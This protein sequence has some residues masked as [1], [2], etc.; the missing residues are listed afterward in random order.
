MIN[1]SIFDTKPHDRTFLKDALAQLVKEKTVSP[2]MELHFIKDHANEETISFAKDSDVVCFFVND[3]INAPLI[4]KL[5]KY[6]VKLIA[7]R[8]AGFNNV[9]LEYLGDKIPIVRV[10]EYSPHAVAEHALALLMTINRK[11]HR[12]YNR[13]R[14]INFSLDGFLGMDLYGKTCGVIGTGKIGATFIKLMLGLG[15]KVI[16]YDVYE[17]EE[18]KK[19][20]NF[21]YVDLDS[22]FPLSDVISLHCPLLP[23]TRYIINS[24]T[25][26]RMKTGVILINTS[27]GSLIHTRDLVQALINGKVGAAGLD[28]YEEEAAYFFEDR[29]STENVVKDEVLARLLGMSNVLMTSH[30]SFFTKEALF[31][32]SKTTINN[33]HLFFDTGELPNK[34]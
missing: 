22:L 12:A 31:N 2:D 23:T 18:L 32:I 8:C 19:L 11:T 29:S 34:V 16:A 25:I 6:G 13:T 33:I 15:M 5:V 21:S 3:I 4:D 24:S 1:I 20:E 27:R 14:E 30:Q 28:V 10:P 7:M 26:N 9:D 17:N